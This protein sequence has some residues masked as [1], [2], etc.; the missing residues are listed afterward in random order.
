[1]VEVCIGLTSIRRKCRVK[2]EYFPSISC[3][4]AAARGHA[5]QT[6]QYG[7]W[8]HYRH[9]IEGRLRR[10]GNSAAKDALR[11]QSPGEARSRVK[12]LRLTRQTM[13]SNKNINTERPTSNAELPMS[14]RTSA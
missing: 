11:Y 4:R 7:W 10:E 2:G 5:M 9:A 13:N 6:L 12:G 8:R 3:G 1:Q 14:K